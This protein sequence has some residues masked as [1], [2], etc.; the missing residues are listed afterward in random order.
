MTNCLGLYIQNNIIKYA[1]ISKEHENFKIDSFGV[2]FYDNLDKAIEQVI[3]ETY[4]YK[5]TI[6]V[7]LSEETYNYFDLFALMNKSDLSKAIKT[8]FDSYCA[9][10]GYNPNV[11]EN[12]YAIVPNADEKEKVKVIFISDNKN[13]LNKTT[14]LFSNYKLT[15]ISPISMSIPNLTKFE[16]KENAL[17]VNIEDKTTIT[18]ILDQ[19][20]YDVT[21]L[22]EGSEDILRKINLVEN[23]YSKA[24]DI[25][26]NI[27]IYT[28]EGK[29]LQEIEASY[30]EY[31][32]PT[33]YSIVGSVRKIINE[34]STQI[35]K[36]YIT[37]TASLIN[38]ID[39]YFQEYLTE[40]KCEILKPDFVKNTGEINIK[41]YIEVNSAISL[42]LMG[43]NE[44]I[45]GMNFKS[46]SLMEKL[47][48]WLKIDVN[49]EKTKKE[50]K[51]LGG[52]L[53]F[54][55]NQ[56][57]DK[58]EINLLRLGIGL[59]ILLIVYC[60][61]SGILNDQ[62]NKKIDEANTLIADTNSQIA[63]ANADDNK[64]KSK[65][66]EYTQMIK[67]LQDLNNKI[68]ETN[69]TR[70]AIPNLLGQ[71]MFVIPENVQITSIQN[72]SGTHIEINAQS[73]KYEQLG[74]LKAKIK[75][76]NILTN[77]ISTTGQ[78]ENSVIT[79][80]IEGD[81]P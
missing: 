59:L 51:N 45:E 18:K 22:E 64:I 63:L 16:P 74:Y 4:S 35:N 58:T 78:K 49:P 34:S 29:E 32:M 7:N 43:L 68:S 41:D 39:L 17:I 21:T 10:K 73:N 9:D 55:F 80:K 6:S 71:I 50:K 23:S 28:S 36:V 46:L 60:G 15:N 24:Y 57:L 75:T 48:D 12:R 47:P 1:K 19:K 30:L 53:T 38:N 13:E 31:V 79:V 14:Q 66:N 65:T 20:I 54:D 27:T 70:N 52:L 2:K 40:V 3:K 67:N 5:S 77:V 26:K 42:A 76:D 81:L 37:G 69:K 44:G 62:I 8:E 25:C 33:L 61:F 56:A 11:F 72:T